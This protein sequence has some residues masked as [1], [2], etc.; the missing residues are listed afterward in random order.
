MRLT[1]ILGSSFVVLASSSALAAC[2]HDSA[3]E[4]RS[5]VAEVAPTAAPPDRE[6]GRVPQQ[7]P[8]AD[9]RAE[10]EAAQ[11]KDGSNLI[12]HPDLHAEASDDGGASPTAADPS[13]SADM[14]ATGPEADLE[15]RAF[16]VKTRERL[17]RIDARAKT[18]EEKGAKLTATKKTSFDTNLRRFTAART[19]AETRLGALAKSGAAWKASRTNVERSVD[20]L[21]SMLSKLDDR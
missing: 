17:A 9:V 12:V 19:D 7:P 14:G 3:A 20:E 11:R 2:A 13:T 4:A 5:A 1:A 15:R 6:Q 16:E 8:S 18:I 21:E 10:L